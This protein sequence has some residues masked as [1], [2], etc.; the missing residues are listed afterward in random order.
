MPGV[1]V[2]IPAYNAESTLAE[3][4][5]S[6]FAQ[7]YGDFEVLVVD[8]GSADAT[9]TVAAASGDPRVR[10]ISVPNGGVSRARNRGVEEAS[11]ELIAFLDADDLWEPDKLERQVSALEAEPQAGLCVTGAVRI[12]TDGRL[13][14]LMPLRNSADVCRTLLLNA[15]AVGCLSSGM[16]RASL[17]SDLGCFDTRFSQCADWDL[18]L[19]ISAA[20]EFCILD[21]PLVRYRTS[22]SNMSS[23]IGLLERDT[24][25]VLDAFYASPLSVPYR[26][27]RSRVYGR[28]WMMCAG[29]YLHS[30]RLRD[31]MRCGLRGAFSDPTSLTRVLGAPARW[32]RR[33]AAR[34]ARAS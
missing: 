32:T 28:Y 5:G 4:L 9:A 33:L 19:R 10:V 20:S 16:A 7:T 27:L 17:L 22:G 30:G 31:A 29:S 25:A 15:M 2:V 23:N 11:A 3:T 18:W 24:F 6:V 14:E 21:A 8:D 12:D 26:S 13:L 34:R 1:S